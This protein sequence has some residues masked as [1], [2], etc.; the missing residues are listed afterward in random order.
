MEKEEEIIEE[1]KKEEKECEE[2]QD[3]PG[4][5]LN[6]AVRQEVIHPEPIPL[7]PLRPLT[8]KK[9]NR[10]HHVL[11]NTL[12]YL[13]EHPKNSLHYGLVLL[14]THCPYLTHLRLHLPI[15]SLVTL[16]PLPASLRSLDIYQKVSSTSFTHLF[17]TPMSLTRLVLRKCEVRDEDIEKMKRNVGDLKVLWL[18]ASKVVTTRRVWAAPPSPTHR[19]I[20]GWV[21]DLRGTLTKLDVSCVGGRMRVQARECLR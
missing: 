9:Y 4:L 17:A 18:P 7:H 19:S 1:N 5:E 14:L 6:E 20:A 15:P 12:P 8:K 13:L 10:D 16:P 3:R 2:L 11:P 21:W